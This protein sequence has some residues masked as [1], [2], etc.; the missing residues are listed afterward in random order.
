MNVINGCLR[1]ACLVSTFLL[2]VGQAT[3]SLAE[4]VLIDF[5]NN[6][7]HYRGIA[8]PAPDENGNFWNSVQP[9]LF[10]PL[11]DVPTPEPGLRNTANAFSTLAIGWDTPVGT[12]SY[13]SPA[14]DTSVGTPA[15]NLPFT[16]ID[17]EALG[18][19]GVKEA[20]FDYA[21]GPINPDP[22]I[23][24]KTRFQIQG[25]SATKKYN[26]TFF[27]SHKF[28]FDATTLYSIYTDNTYSTLVTST[29]L[30]HQDPVD[31]TAYNRDRVATISDLSPQTD[32]ILYLEFVGMQTGDLGY[33]NSLMIESVD[34]PGLIGDYNNSGAVDAADYTVWRNNVGQPGTVLENRSP[35]VTGNVQQQDYVVWKANFG[36]PGSGSGASVGAPVPEPTTM[37]LCLIA[38]VGAACILRHHH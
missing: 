24:N 2:L 10:Y 36:L 32:N 6:E 7:D 19:L 9:G 21:T 3:F 25:L 14:G 15:D 34:G 23:G 35:D 4:I 8:V 12:D 30:D 26:L 17:A 29:T 11:Q 28:S 22:V 16:D 1:N 5:G 37:I 38:S 13:N 18:I 33:L 31:F 20:A 27:A